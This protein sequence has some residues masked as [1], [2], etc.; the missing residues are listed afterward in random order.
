MTHPGNTIMTPERLNSASV[1]TVW[2]W[3]SMFSLL[4]REEN[5]E[6]ATRMFARDVVAFGT[7]QDS[8]RGLD[9]LIARQWR[10]IWGN[11]RGFTFDAE[12]AVVEVHGEMAWA[13][14]TWISEK[15]DAAGAWVSRPGRSTFVLKWDGDG[16]KAVHSHLSL[17]PSFL[18]IK[19]P[20][21]IVI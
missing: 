7:L 5:Y 2:S 9:D 12:G 14:L 11:T 17:N 13:A 16:W 15:Q 6:A 20:I 10:N 4:V 3:L 1:E 18:G 21:R 8:M 19:K